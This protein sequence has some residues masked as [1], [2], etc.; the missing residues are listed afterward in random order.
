[1]NRQLDIF[2]MNS[3]HNSLPVRDV[4]TLEKY[5]EKAKNQDGLILEFFKSNP[6]NSFTPA[7]VFEIFDQKYPITSIRRAITNL[8]KAGKLELTGE[9]RKGLYGRE[10]NTWRVKK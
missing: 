1:M 2:S 9:T 7:R 6:N 3:F 10:N 8:T 5:E 4:E